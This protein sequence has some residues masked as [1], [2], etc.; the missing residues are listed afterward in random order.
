MILMRMGQNDADEVLLL[1]F[2]E[3]D[4]RHDEIDARQSFLV[5]ERHAA[6]DHEPVTA[7]ALRQSVD[8]QVHADFADTAKRCENQFIRRRH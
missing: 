8:R 6:I 4:I 2:Q 5:A 3:A 7:L 1:G